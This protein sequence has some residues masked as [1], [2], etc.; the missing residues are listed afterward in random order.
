VK[1]HLLAGARPNYMK[2]F[3]LMREM[4]APASPFRPVLIHTGQ[5]Y[6]ALMNDVFFEDFGVS[7]PDHFLGVGSGPHGAQTAKVMMGLEELFQRERPDALVVVGDV[8]STMAGALVAVK[9]GIPVAHLEA[10]LRSGDRTMPEEIN[11]IVTDSISDLLLTSCRDAD[12]NLRREGIPAERIRFVGNIMI[13]SLVQILPKAEASDIT[14]RLGV[15]PGRYCL[16]TL[17]RPSNVDVPARLALIVR[18]LVELAKDLPV[19]F[20]VHPRTRKM[21]DALSDLRPLTSDLRLL[22]PLGYLDFLALQSRAGVVV[23]DSGGVQEETSFLGIPCL[24]L[25]TNTERPVTV[26]AGTNR[27]VDP[28]RDSLC[29]EC[30]SAM[31]RR[32]APR[33]IE[34]WDG[35][36]ASRVVQ[37][38]RDWLPAM[39][40]RAGGT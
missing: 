14:A 10:G 24:T 16:V 12:E 22:A 20:P 38:L 19:V 6:D 2:V 23:T 5:H 40:D 29:E 3:P 13:D 30:V 37:V 1:I 39:K 32:A 21:L 7:K 26:A 9:M 17:H 27:L 18:Q 33:P 34:L 35:R 8:N 11:R 28:T 4:S 36:T 31:K 25:R 15:K